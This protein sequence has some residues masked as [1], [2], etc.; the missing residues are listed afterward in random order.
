MEQI[1]KIKKYFDIYK[2]FY[3][4]N[5][6]VFEVKNL[7][8]YD[9]NYYLFTTKDYNLTDDGRDLVWRDFCECEFDNFRFEFDLNNL[10][11]IGRTSSFLLIPEQLKNY[12]EY[13]DYK[14]ADNFANAC[15]LYNLPA[16]HFLGCFYQND[17]ALKGLENA[18]QDILNDLLENLKEFDIQQEFDE[19]IKIN[20]YLNEFKK[21]QV[22]IIKAYCES[23]VELIEEE[24]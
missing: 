14:S 21:N 19:C 2:N 15:I 10:N 1:E 23:A 17:L 7:K 8:C 24:E 12:F 13:N 11:Y 22:E 16:N 20:N 3:E 4:S 5:K 9:A 6:N 18:D